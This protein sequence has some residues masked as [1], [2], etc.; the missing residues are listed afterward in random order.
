MITEIL[1]ATILFI[2]RI[3]MECLGK[4]NHKNRDWESKGWK[5]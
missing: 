4:V 1:Y 5:D 2:P 3:V